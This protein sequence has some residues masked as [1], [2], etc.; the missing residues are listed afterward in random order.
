MLESTFFTQEP[1]LGCAVCLFGIAAFRT[2]LTCISW[3]NIFD[4]TPIHFRFVIQKRLKSRKAPR[5]YSSTGL[6]SCLNFVPNISQILKNYGCTRLNT[7]DYSSRQNV[8]TISAETVYLPANFL[9]M[10]LGRFGAFRLQSTSQS[11]ISMFY[12]FPLAFS[13]EN[14]IT[15]NC[16]SINAKIYTQ[17]LVC[18]LK[19]F[20]GL[21]YN[22]VKNRPLILKYKIRRTD[23]P[24]DTLFVKFWY[25]Q[26]ASNP[27]IDTCKSCGTGTKVYTCRSCIIPNNGCIRMWTYRLTPLFKSC[28]G[29]FNGLCCLNAGRADKLTWKFRNGS[30]VRIGHFMQFNAVQPLHF[31]AGLANTVIRVTTL[32][33]C[34]IKN[35]KSIGFDWQFKC[36]SYKVILFHICSIT[37]RW[38]GVKRRKEVR[39]LPDMNVEVSALNIL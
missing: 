33:S 22:N 35:I 19:F 16:W 1:R 15:S 34:S 14:R 37:H 23:F 36:Q 9:Q 3:I 4:N 2:F 24:F 20:I 11:K 10:S 27:P 26:P 6:F 12:F 32:L 25:N 29:T 17:Y 28:S 30:L 18:S 39:F 38:K 7:I 8:I 5:V 13:K 21:F 31:P